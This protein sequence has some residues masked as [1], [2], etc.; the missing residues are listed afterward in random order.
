M[1]LEFRIEVKIKEI[2]GK[3]II[4]QKLFKIMWNGEII[5][6]K[7]VNNEEQKLK[8]VFRFWRNSNVYMLG[9]GIGDRMIMVVVIIGVII[10]IM[11]CC[12]FILN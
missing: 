5:L 1:S 7:N 2:F 6:G 11:I 9:G 10:R 4:L 8:E 12:V 3:I